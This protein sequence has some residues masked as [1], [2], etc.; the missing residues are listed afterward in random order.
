MLFLMIILNEIK[1][2]VL[3][4][5]LEPIVENNLFIQSNISLKLNL[6]KKACLKYSKNIFIEK[7][8]DD[9]WWKNFLCLEGA[10]KKLVC[11]FLFFLKSIVRLQFSK[12]VLEKSSNITIFLTKIFLF[13]FFLKFFFILKWLLKVDFIIKFYN[14]LKISKN[15]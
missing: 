11:S 5:T 12:K 8:S 1:S 13:A 7:I 15:K 6:T 14:S 10:F 4:K 3:V 9:I 2:L